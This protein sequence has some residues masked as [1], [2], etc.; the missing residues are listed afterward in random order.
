VKDYDRPVEFEPAGG[1]LLKL[2]MST[3]RN[4]VVAAVAASIALPAA[5]SEGDMAV[6]AYE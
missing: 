5:A 4:I 6:S 2:S 3:T 1:Q